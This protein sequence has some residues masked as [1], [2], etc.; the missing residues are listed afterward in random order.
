MQA[1]I[2][3]VDGVL[4]DS[5]PAHFRAF[6]QLAAE[7][8]WTVTDAQLRTTFGMHNQS[9]MPMLAGRPLSDTQWRALAD[10]KEGLYRAL[11]RD[12]LAAI[13]GA[14]DLVRACHGAG[15]L[16]AVG[17]SGPRA[18]VE[19]ALATLGIRALFGAVIT[20]DDVRQGKPDPEIFLAAASTLG[21]DP[22]RC[23]V[24]E[25]AP[26]GVEAAR[27]AG[28]RVVAVTTSR[29]RADLHRAHLVVD[30]LTH[31]TVALLRGDR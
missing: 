26:Q 15:L 10:H 12:H 24:V 19:L 4:V 16:L 14:V 21:V 28:M 20:G 30:S 31:A 8:G 23:V 27:A 1:I 18:N 25:D 17:S 5:N 2:F 29:P 11:A 9:I 13:D 3:D 7:Q 6:H 22:G